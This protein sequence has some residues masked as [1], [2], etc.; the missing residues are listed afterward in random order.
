ML[1][2]STPRRQVLVLVI[3]FVLLN[4]IF[5]L[6][7]PLLPFIDLPNHLAESTIFKFHGHAGN[8]FSRYYQPE[9]WYYPNTFHTFFCSLFPS[10]ELG[11]K[12]F[13][14][15]YIALL[16]VAI[17]LVARQL[18]G[19][20]WY[21]LLGVLFTYNYNVTYGF[22]GFAM[23]I[24]MLIFLF[25]LTL[26]NIAQDRWL[27]K[28]AISC[29]LVLIFLMHAQNALLALL[30]YGS[31]VL[32]HHKASL[33][34]V[35]ADGILVSLPLIVLI[36]VWWSGRAAG[37]EGSTFEYLA[38]YY[39]SGYLENFVI[40]FRIIVFD[41]FQLREGVAGLIF[42][43][44]FFGCLVF[45]LLFSR[46]WREKP[47]R[48]FVTQASYILLFFVIAL[49]CYLILP[50]KLPGQMPLFQRFCT[51]VILTFIILAS[52]WIPN[53]GSRTLKYFVIV[54]CAIYTLMWFEYIYAFNRQNKGFNRELFEGI[55]N[56]STL[57]GLIYANDFRG[58]KVYIHFPNYFIVWN[59]GIAASKIIDYRFG[60]I[61]RVGAE[62][63]LPFYHELIGERYRLQ[64]QYETMDYLLSR[65]EAPVIPDDNL[66]GFILARTEGEWRL[67]RR[68]D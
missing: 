46:P 67:F 39:A 64:P 19:N 26:L 55:S 59:Q 11:N 44:A 24:P 63:S 8:I 68:K 47:L 22:V 32:Y 3:A 54:A 45:P 49:L 27:L 20:P 10:V 65:G 31:M 4:A 2:T 18:N 9:P 1:N 40:R 52:V 38:D 15:L 29:L 33:R 35:L 62:D 23:S 56:R 58:R 16:Q 53:T 14:I 5:L 7:M 50:D 28:T 51:I 30:L 6:W 41:N 17:F 42:A 25:H 60:V 48:E 13:H 21:G 34:K 43:A 12:I 36:V 61:R 57:A 37:N 66:R